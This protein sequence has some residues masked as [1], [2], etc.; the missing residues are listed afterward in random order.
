MDYKFEE[1]VFSNNKIFKKE[2]SEPTFSQKKVAIIAHVFY[3]DLW[4]EIEDYLDK[5]SIDYDV[6]VT[7]PPIME[8]S[9]IAKLFKSGKN[10]K[11]FMPENR[12]RDVL[13]FL[14]VL[15]YIGVDSY[16]YICKLHTKKTGNSPLGH[17]WRKLL[18]FDLL[19]DPK[20]VVQILE[21]FEKDDSIGEVTGKSMVLD[22]KRYA[23]GNNSKIRELCMLSGIEF[24]EDYTFSGGTMFWTRTSCL[25]PIIK[26]FKEGKLKFEEERGQKDHTLAHALER[27]FGIVVQANGK[28]IVPSPADYSLLP[29]S[30]V[31][32]TASLVLS[33]QYAGQDVYDKINELNEYIHELEA[34]AESM[35]LKNR[36]KR[37]PKDILKLATKKVSN[38]DSNNITSKI[39]ELSRVKKVITTPVKIAKSNPAALKKVFY[40]AKRGEFGYLISKVKQKISKNLNDSKEFTKIE[41]K[42]YFEAFKMRKFHLGSQRVDIII[43]VYNGYEYLDP[44]FKSLRA[45][46]SHPHRVIVINDASPDER[47]L[48]LLEAVL[49]EFEDSILINNKENLGFVQSVNKA[50]QKAE[51]NFVILNT[52]TE[53]PPFWLERLMYPIVNMENIATTTPFTNSGTVA[54]FP[55][56]LEDNEIFEGLD[57]TTL[58][59]AFKE[60]NAQKHYA[61]LPTGVGFCMGVNFS[62]VQKIGFFDEQSF[63]RGYGE[64]ND[65]CQRAIK[66]GYS[67]LLVPNLFVYHKHGG[68]FPSEVKQK[69]LQEN[70]AKLLAKHPDYDKQIQ[71]Y[72]I[73]NPH[74]I[75]RE[76]LIITASSKKEP[77]WV[78]F[79]H[80]LGGGANSYANEL[81]QK[82]FNLNKNILKIAYDF[83]TGE[84]KC[85]YL[86]KEYKFNFAISSLEQLDI[87]LSRC[88]I[89]EIFLNSL[90]SYKH[91][92]E[93]IEY[94]SKLIDSKKAKLTIPIHDYFSV[95]PSYTL[96]NSEG[97]YCNVPNIK[98]CQECMANSKQEWRNFMS[99]EI[100][101]VTWRELWSNL[102]NKANKILAFSNSSKEIILKAYPELKE[103]KIEL[104][105]H[106]VDGFEALNL[107]KNENKKNITIGI[108]GAI[109]YAKGANI[110]KELVKQIDK[111]NLDIQ[112]VVIGEIT[113]QISSPNFKVTGRYK[114]EELANIIKTNEIDIFLIP[115]IWPETFSYTTQEIIN[116]NIP[117]I[118][119][120]LG[121]PAERVKKYKKGYIINNIN[122]NDILNT[123]DNFKKNS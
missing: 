27:F 50:V 62:L 116:M 42:E 76:L 28:K 45:N 112:V 119:F 115:S 68:S 64:E 97:K 113:E 83:Y 52:D 99:E 51:G 1:I 5:L 87:L 78:M 20:A 95:C 31:E 24:K 73:K 96:L 53:V 30:T 14:Q 58:D 114:K 41:L 46:T 4:Q 13:P 82:Q 48:P 40:Y 102:L 8:D 23:Y 22:S 81:I 118:V 90:V 55:K 77:L 101:I 75:L 63:G 36:L 86:Y 15:N 105:P 107:I 7:V 109:N 19:G 111:D 16:K 39:P 106:K 25:E 67:N 44:L 21:N 108:L 6:F 84:Y 38:F 120:N 88:K 12:G 33:Q 121:A 11:V 43:P 37:L 89:G 93:T 32:Q 110:V 98:S 61:K 94:I 117:L 104:I 85:N 59:S 66:E 54:S 92:K 35:R 9:D 122:V 2:P 79:D 3:I 10:I 18:Y 57:L 80:A 71:E 49:V 74:K 72:I 47:V 103:E 26:L 91:Q 65:W 69:L 60:V 70:H 17:V 29:A 100:D 56:F 34:L 123:I